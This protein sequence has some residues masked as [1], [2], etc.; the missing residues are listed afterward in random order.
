MEVKARLLKPSSSHT[1]TDPP[2]DLVGSIRAAHIIEETLFSNKTEEDKTRDKR[3]KCLSYP[4]R[5]GYEKIEAN[6]VVILSF[7]SNSR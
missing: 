6:W 7:A 5:Q 4:M 1:T 3:L 2:R